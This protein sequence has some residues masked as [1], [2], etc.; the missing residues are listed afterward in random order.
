MSFANNMDRAGG[1]SLFVK[2]VYLEAGRTY[3]YKYT[4]NNWGWIW[5]FADY[6]LDG[7][8]QDFLGKNPD[9]VNSRLEDLKVYGH[10]TTHAN[11]PAL[12]VKPSVT[13]Y[14]TF[15]VNLET[16]AYSVSLSNSKGS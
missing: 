9:A 7:Y 5:V 4:A 6:E 11:P 15:M 3:E 14:Y 8:G 12:Q 1:K 16:G 13:G 2:D 10:L